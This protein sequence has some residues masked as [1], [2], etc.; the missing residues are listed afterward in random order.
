MIAFAA[1]PG[2]VAY[3]GGGVNSPFTV[4]LVEHLASPSLEVGTA[5]KRVIREVRAKTGNKQSPQI[6]SNLDV[7]VLFQ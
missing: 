4:A 6:V 3:D 7:R 5:F 2:Q 1:S